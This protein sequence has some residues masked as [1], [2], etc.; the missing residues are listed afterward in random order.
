VDIDDTIF[1][2]KNNSLQI[3]ISE[4]HPEGQEKSLEKFLAFKIVLYELSDASKDP[5]HKYLKILNR[6]P[7]D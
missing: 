2:K 4:S 1:S 7:S 6:D 3:L 5:K